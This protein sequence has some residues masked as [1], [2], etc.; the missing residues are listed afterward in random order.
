MASRDMRQH[1]QACSP[2]SVA[3][4]HG[5]RMMRSSSDSFERLR[6]GASKD[7]RSGRSVGWFRPFQA[8]S[9]IRTFLAPKSIIICNENDPTSTNYRSIRI[10][11]GGVV[12]IIS[13][14]S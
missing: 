12:V 8:A 3:T 7:G 13:M 2:R 1:R 10:L 11:F 5:W 9:S 6:A 14:N 4:H